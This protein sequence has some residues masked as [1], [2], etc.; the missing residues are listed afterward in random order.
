[1]KQTQIKTLFCMV[2][3]LATSTI[4]VL[5]LYKW[6]FESV[7]HRH[8]NVVFTA[9]ESSDIQVLE[10]IDLL[11]S[12]SRLYPSSNSKCTTA[13]LGDMRAIEFQSRWLKDVSYIFD[14]KILCTT[15]LGI[16]NQP[17]AAEKFIISDGETGVFYNPVA[18]VIGI[19]PK[20]REKA[21]LVGNFQSYIRIP[22]ISGENLPWIDYVA[23]ITNGGIH[24]SKVSGTLNLKSLTI[25]E[26]DNIENWYYSN[27]YFGKS[28]VRN[29][30]CIIVGVNLIE[31]FKHNLQA[32]V[33]ITI[34]LAFVSV[35]AVLYVLKLLRQYMLL[36]NQLKRGMNSRQIICHY[37]PI[38]NIETGSFPK[39]EVLSRWKNED[40][41]LVRPD[42][43]IS[44][45]EENQQTSE[46]T[47]VVFEKVINEL[48][49]SSLW[50][51]IHFALN[52]YPQDLSSGFI[53]KMIDSSLKDEEKSFVTIEVTE[54]ELDDINKVAEEIKQ[55]RKRG[56]LVAIDDFGTGYSNFQHLEKL[57][58]DALKI[59]K[60]FVQ[61]IENNSL[62]SKLTE[63]IIEI[64]KAL[65]L[66]TVAEGVEDL[67]QL[68]VLKVLDVDYTQGFYHAKPMPIDKLVEF[69]SAQD[70]EREK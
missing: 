60:S 34:V 7:W 38:M 70:L 23:Y 10:E 52:V 45:I 59:D 3:T 35:I 20:T 17:V 27:T 53:K 14:N 43:F 56:C 19:T 61:G 48:K 32:L 4:F 69:L 65:R 16:L 47:Q 26:N 21:I 41:E 6:V 24:K 15:R 5:L 29:T 42:I 9:H 44:Q 64:S 31:Y 62:R 55:L 30:N 37:Q 39:V 33:A 25:P 12:L 2:C 57:K 18:T 13:I 11:H 66:V 54:Q 1:M 63:S 36:R 58:V 68:K 51:K 50:G 8:Q 46:F 40:D 22:P 67:T 49:R 28:C